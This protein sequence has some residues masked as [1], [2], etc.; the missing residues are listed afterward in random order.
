M[1]FASSGLDPLAS[2]RHGLGCSLKETAADH[3][4]RCIGM[5]QDLL[6]IVQ[7]VIVAAGTVAV[8]AFAA[9]IGKRLSR[10][11]RKITWKISWGRRLAID[12]GSMHITIVITI[13]GG[14]Q[15]QKS[16]PRAHD[17]KRDS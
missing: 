15:E 3:E 8:V 17:D 5:F 10:L 6:S 7:Q 14:S 11:L 2:P 4:G 9:T 1:G 13:G 12:V 16:L